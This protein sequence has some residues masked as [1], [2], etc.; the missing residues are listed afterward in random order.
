MA[1]VSIARLRHGALRSHFPSLLSIWMICWR[2]S[3]TM[4]REFTRVD[5]LHQKGKSGHRLALS[6][7]DSP[8]APNIAIAK[9][10]SEVAQCQT[11]T[12]A[13]RFEFL[14]GHQLS[15]CRTHFEAL[16]ATNPNIQKPIS[17]S[18]R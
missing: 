16:K 18:T 1:S 4:L 9:S 8:K 7:F 14:A 17:G 15:P 13:D 10:R 11:S 5:K 2:F 6:I 12:Y 3:E